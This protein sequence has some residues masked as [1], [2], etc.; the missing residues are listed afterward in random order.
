[1]TELG[2]PP[3]QLTAVLLFTLAFTRQSI[4]GQVPNFHADS[5]MCSGRMEAHF[6]EG[7]GRDANKLLIESDSIREAYRVSS[8]SAACIA[9]KYLSCTSNCSIVGC[10]LLYLRIVMQVITS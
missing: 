6:V 7:C 9:E 1:L 5:I 3:K 4:S 2:M 8:K 10:S